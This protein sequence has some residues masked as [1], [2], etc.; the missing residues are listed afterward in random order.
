MNTLIKITAF[1]ASSF[2]VLGL[3][4]FKI[5]IAYLQQI[6]LFLI[7][8]LVLFS[9]NFSSAKKKGFLQ[10]GLLLAITFFIQL[11]ITS[12]GA[13]FSPFIVLIH[14]YV[15]GLSL[16]FDF[17]TAF[18]FLLTEV[19]VLYL[20]IRIDSNLLG[21]VRNDLGTVFIYATSFLV[22]TPVSKL[23]AQ[24]YHL[25]GEALEDLFKKLSVED[26]IIGQIEDFV[27]ITNRYL[28]VLSTNESAQKIINEKSISQN[29]TDIISLVDLKGQPVTQQSLASALSPII[30]NL[31]Q[32]EITRQL[33]EDI[34]KMNLIIENYSLKLP[35]KKN[36]LPVLIR[37]NPQLNQNGALEKFVFLISRKEGKSHLEV[38]GFKMQEAHKRYLLVFS[39]LKKDPSVT[40]VPKVNFYLDLLAKLEEDILATSN[41]SF[42]STNLKFK[43]SDLMPLFFQIMEE[44][45][46][47]GQKLNPHFQINLEGEIAKLYEEQQQKN[48]FPEQL[49]DL[50]ILTLITNPQLVEILIKKLL[51]FMVILGYISKSDHLQIEVRTLPDKTEIHLKVKLAETDEKISQL[52]NI[53]TGNL[54]FL[55]T[56]ILS[57]GLESYIISTAANLLNS[58]I[59]SDYNKYNSY[60]TVSINLNKQ[61]E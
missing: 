6:L 30:H 44:G 54:E 14:L 35:N 16:L 34:S 36:P 37:I 1:S 61:P 12:T 11:L 31:L 58:S 22:I 10:W 33:P 15:I 4:F 25:K 57:S 56:Q 9:R 8:V 7:V 40:A 27:F 28:K 20:N 60:L 41:L 5:K 23:I 26:S 13:I 21:L 2:L 39:G 24:Q 38:L 18:S 49:R 59:T 29:L 47:F 51:S 46:Q 32:T 53:N 50:S 52:L 45:K 19:L 48:K 17:K 3:I 42:Y 55:N 43:V